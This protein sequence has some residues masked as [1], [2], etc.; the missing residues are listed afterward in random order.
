MM[1]KTKLR[2]IFFQLFLREI[3]TLIIGAAEIILMNGEVEKKRWRIF[4]V[5]DQWFE[6]DLVRQTE[7]LY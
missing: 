4:H 7:S 6:I 2:I 1:K 3:E 5:S